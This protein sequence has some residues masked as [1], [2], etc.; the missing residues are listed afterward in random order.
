MA[1]I[2]IPGGFALR[3]LRQG[4]SIASPRVIESEVDRGDPKRRLASYGEA[5][6]VNAVFVLTRDET[7]AFW[8][9]YDGALG[10]GVYWFNWTHPRTGAAVEAQFA[11]ERAVREDAIPGG[12]Y[13]LTCQMRIR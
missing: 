5:R 1:Q 4:L 12:R 6:P 3:P 9:W 13:K 10:G 8:T 2:D 11:G 7:A